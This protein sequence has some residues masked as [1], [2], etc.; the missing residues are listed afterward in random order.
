MT[1][2]EKHIGFE[3]HQAVLD[4]L[5]NTPALDLRNQALKLKF[6]S[7]CPVVLENDSPELRENLNQ[8]SRLIFQYLEFTQQ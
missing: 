7:W 8:A 2:F 1:D 5:S 3:L 4:H 6:D